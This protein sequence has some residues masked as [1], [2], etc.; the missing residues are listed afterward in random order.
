VTFGT[1]KRENFIIESYHN[2]TIID[3]GGGD[4]YT[5]YPRENVV[6]NITDFNASIDIINLQA[7]HYIHSVYDLNITIVY[8]NQST[9]SSLSNSFSSSSVF[10]MKSSEL[11]N[12]NSNSTLTEKPFMIT[13][14]FIHSNQHVFL[15]DIK[16]YQ[17]VQSLHFLFYDIVPSIETAVE[18]KWWVQQANLGGMIAAAFFLI[19]CISIGIGWR[20][21]YLKYVR[22]GIGFQL[23]HGLTSASSISHL[24]VMKKNQIM[25][26]FFYKNHSIRPNLQAELA[27]RNRTLDMYAPYLRKPT[28]T[29]L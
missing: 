19:L 27:D 23:K 2:V 11:L 9:E 3:N 29:F 16:D 20:Y 10:K 12:E 6:I 25:D 26:I 5:I 14:T 15:W 1:V 8:L 24:P 7:F 18:V 4:I 13:I 21:Y 22:K 17:I 28:S